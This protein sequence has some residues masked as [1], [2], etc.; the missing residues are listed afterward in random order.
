MA[1]GKSKELEEKARQLGLDPEQYASDDELR[2]AIKAAES[3]SEDNQPN[4]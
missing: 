2:E 1:K 3:Q 4:Q